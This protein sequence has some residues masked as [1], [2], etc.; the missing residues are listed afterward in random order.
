MDWARRRQIIVIAVLAVAVLLLLAGV[1]FAAFYRVPTCFDRTQNQGEAGVDCG[2]PCNSLC[3]AD[4]T[5]PE[6]LFTRAIASQPGRLDAISYVR[7]PNAHAA[8]SR[9]RGV[10][11]LYDAGQNLIAKQNVSFDLPPGRPIPVYLPGIAFTDTPVARAFLTIDQSSV[12][13][14]QTEASLELPKVTDIKTEASV[15][16][17]ITATLNN[18]TAYPIEGITMIAVVFDGEDNA[19]AASR[20]VV[21][22]LPPQGTAPMVFTWNVPFPGDAVRVEIV[23]LVSVRAPGS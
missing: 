12:K 21:P 2:G 1:A 9:V 23:P 3:T 16:P 20:T 8:A 22:S 7:N 18:V 10:V 4:A 6:V 19:I 15:R 14:F 17:R 13:W 5:A 11:E